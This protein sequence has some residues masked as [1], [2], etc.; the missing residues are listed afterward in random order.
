MKSI[1]KKSILIFTTIFIF[2]VAKSQNPTIKGNL[3]ANNFNTGKGSFRLEQIVN[4]K[5]KDTVYSITFKDMRYPS[6]VSYTGITLKKL[7][8][9]D[10]LFKICEKAMTDI[11][12]INY[13]YVDGCK[14]RQFY[15]LGKSNEDMWNKVGKRVY[16]EA[17]DGV[18]NKLTEKEIDELKNKISLFLKTGHFM[19]E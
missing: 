6:L 13:E 5:S 7:N 14:I 19:D 9:V 18:F 17:K 2:I 8:Q 10:T 4:K 1:T 3:I 16:I 11:E 12:N 15:T